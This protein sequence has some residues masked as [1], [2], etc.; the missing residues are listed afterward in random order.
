MSLRTENP[1][2]TFSEIF[3]LSCWF[4]LVTEKTDTSEIYIDNG[5]TFIWY[6]FCLTS[7]NV[8]INV[9]AVSS[10][11]LNILF[12]DCL[13]RQRERSWYWSMDF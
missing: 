6:L 3:F 9:T 8:Y 2:T 5:E 7:Y 10:L 1:A 4:Y 11:F 12:S 13:K